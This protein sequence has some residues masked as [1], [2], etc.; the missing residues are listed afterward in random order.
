MRLATAIRLHG[1]IEAA[2]VDGTHVRIVEGA[3]EEGLHAALADVLRSPSDAR[4][5]AVLC[6]FNNTRVVLNGRIRMQLGLDGVVASEDTLICLRNTRF[7]PLL[8]ANGMRGMVEGCEDEGRDQ[9]R[10][11]VRFP[12]DGLLLEGSLCR[13]QVGRPYSFQSF[14]DAGPIDGREPKEWGDLGLLFD[15]GY[16]L[17]VH[18]A[19]GSQFR[20]VV[21]ILERSAQAG[22]EYYRRWLYTAVTRAEEELVLVEGGSGKY[23][24]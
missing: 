8:L 1:E 12:D 11:T 16:A 23:A 6:Y 2:H 13:A 5:T 14:C 18:K 19:Q 3:R 21:V 4:D 10:A 22:G 9:I 15:H 20:R 24:R 17:T 7:G